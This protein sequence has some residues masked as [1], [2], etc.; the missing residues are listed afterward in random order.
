MALTVVQAEAILIAAEGSRLYAYIVVSLLTGARTEE[1]RA[2]IW[3]HVDLDGD[4]DASPPVP[5]HV[6]VWRSVRTG[7]DTKTRKSRRTL[8]LPKRCVDALHECER[9]GLPQADSASA[10]ARS[11]R[12][13]P[14][15]WRQRRCVVTQL[16]TQPAGRA[17]AASADRL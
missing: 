17:E 8:A 14:H 9:V 11:R 12:H 2:L 16:V 7:G 15:L 1:L 5:P 10:T 4:P 3:D 13:G 6:A